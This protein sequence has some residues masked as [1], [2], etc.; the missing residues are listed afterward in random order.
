VN[1]NSKLITKSLAFDSQEEGKTTITKLRLLC[2]DNIQI[3]Y[4]K[5]KDEILQ[6]SSP[7]LSPS[8]SSL[9]NSDSSPPHSSLSLS[10]HSSSDD[11]S[12]SYENT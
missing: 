2:L 7:S 6:Q 3:T 1:Q 12:L 11:D 8:L 4:L 9:S 5:W 10:H